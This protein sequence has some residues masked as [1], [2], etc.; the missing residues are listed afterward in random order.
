M[1]KK[2]LL[3]ALSLAAAAASLTT[4]SA[5]AGGTH[6]CPRCTTYADGSQ[7]CVSCVCNS[8]GFPIACTNNYCPP[9]GGGV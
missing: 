7:C 1:R 5:V 3:L 9:A 6:A 8:S 2:M 4:P